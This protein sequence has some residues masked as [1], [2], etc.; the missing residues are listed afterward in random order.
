MT[1]ALYYPHTQIQT[2]AALNN[3]LLLWDHI[4]TIVPDARWQ[5]EDHPGGELVQEAFELVVRRRIPT[6]Q[7]RQ[8]ANKVLCEMADD[9]LFYRLRKQSPKSWTGMEYLIHPEK[10]LG[11]TWE[12]LER[13]GIARWVDHESDY[14]VPVGVGLLMMSVLADTCA[15]TRMQKVTDREDAYNWLAEYRA[16]EL[17]SQWI[18]GIDASQIASYDRLVTLSVNLLDAREIPLKKLV[19]LRKD[20]EKNPGMGLKNMRRRFQKAMS[21]Y[22]S[23]IGR[24]SSPNDLAD[25]N[26]NFYDDLK[27]D[28]AELKSELQLVT[29]KVLLKEVILSTVFLAGCFALPDGQLSEIAKMIGP[30]GIMPL[31]KGLIEYKAARNAA[32]KKHTMSWLYVAKQGRLPLL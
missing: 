8:K 22:I 3:A 20:E 5:P 30:L 27:G 1:K 15:G 26:E 13:G 25:I 14:G 32:L 6:E 16:T 18:R 11:R 7:E 24:A 17:G 31:T 28:L 12:W 23:S 9:G 21:D 2:A 19:Q 10:F 4:E 29:A